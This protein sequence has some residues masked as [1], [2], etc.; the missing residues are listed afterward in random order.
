[1]LRVIGIFALV[2]LAAGIF[3]WRTM[4]P[5]APLAVPARGVVLEDVTVVQP[6]AGRYPAQRIVVEG[7]RIA[8]MGPAS[9][10][11]APASAGAD[12]ELVGSFALPGLIDMHVHFPP[13]TGGRQ[14]EIF[15]FLFLMHGVTSVRDAA[16]VDG[17]SSRPVREGVHEGRFPGPRSFACGPLVDGTEPLW[18]N[19]LIVRDAAEAEAAVDQIAAEGWDCVKVYNSLTPEALAGLHAAA[20]RHGL[21]VIG[22]VPARTSFDEA[23]LDDAQHLIGVAREKGDLRSFPQVLDAWRSFDAAK[24][25]AIIEASLRN[26][27]A[28]TPT[29][30]VLERGFAYRDYAALYES[31]DAKL[32][33]PL[34][35]DVIWSPVDG[36]PFLR[37]QTEERHR[38]MEDAYLAGTALVGRMHRA[39]VRIH[40]GTDTQIA[41]IVPGAGLH[42]ELRILSDAAGLGPEAALAAATTVPGPALNLAKLGRIVPG[43]PADLVLFRRDPTLD[44]DA[45]DE[46]VA[47][48]ADGRLY[49]RAELDAQM[50]RYREYY[51]DP[52]FDRL[53]KFLAR[54][55]LARI[56]DD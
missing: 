46:I 13:D 15:A 1:M 44:L 47:V 52:V 2:L 3:L 45:L 10:D 39:G 56:F 22:H 12:A 35:R 30:V 5:P 18:S 36:M 53:S 50:D 25:A 23:R 9:A 40:A 21:P 16:D 20:D 42:R 43:A 48:V 32:L 54:R 29:F 14:E 11:G 19:S 37:N 41:Y 26:G 28:H 24:E 33:P 17:T 38:L 31:P 49:R 55:A 8:A 51:D 27:T 34:Y 6:G 4:L 7:G